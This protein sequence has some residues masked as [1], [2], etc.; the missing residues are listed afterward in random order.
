MYFPATR[1][2]AAGVGVP[3]DELR[4]TSSRMASQVGSQAAIE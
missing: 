4:R 1:S 3:S 2:W